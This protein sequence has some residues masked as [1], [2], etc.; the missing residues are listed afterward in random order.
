MYL[1]FDLEVFC[2]RQDL[3]VE[4]KVPN[5]ECNLQRTMSINYADQQV[6]V[7]IV[8]MWSSPTR[9]KLIM[10]NSPTQKKK[11][12]VLISIF[13]SPSVPCVHT[14]GSF[15]LRGGSKNFLVPNVWMQGRCSG[16]KGDIPNTHAMVLLLLD[17]LVNLAGLLREASE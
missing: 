11:L 5:F 1:C 14:H 9:K 16:A 6:S 8:V 4:S 17:A 15:N 12:V 10:W 13:E 3:T 7:T 2:F